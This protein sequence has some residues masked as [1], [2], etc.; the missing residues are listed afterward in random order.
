VKYGK[1]QDSLKAFDKRMGATPEAINEEFMRTKARF[2]KA[3]RERKGLE[4]ILSQL[5]KAFSMRI[6]MFRAFQRHIS[7]RSRINFAYLLSERAFRGKLTIDHIAKKLDVHVEPDETRKNGKGRSTKTLSGGEKSFSSICL[8]LSLWE[9]MGAPLRCLDEFD[10]F[11]DDVNRDISTKMIVGFPCPS[12][13][14]SILTFDRLV[15]LESLLDD[16]SFSS[17]LR[18]SVLVSLTVQRT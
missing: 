6:D 16:N 3:Y 10:V 2:E 7:A 12:S 1:L 4:V 18:R 15:L 9:A 11:M 13:P 5:K 14:G 17:R 8:L